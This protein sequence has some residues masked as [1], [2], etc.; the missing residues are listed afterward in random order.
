MKSHRAPRSRDPFPIRH[1]AVIFICVVIL[2]A[3]FVAVS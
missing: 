3:L 1:F 2:V